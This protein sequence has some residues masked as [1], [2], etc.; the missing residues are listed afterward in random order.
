MGIEYRIVWKR[1]GCRQKAKRFVSL[2]AAQRKM[3]VLGPEPWTAFDKFSGRDEP[4]NYSC[5]D[6]HECG[7]GGLTV[8]QWWKQLGL[9]K[10]EYIHIE[11]REVGKWTLPGDTGTSVTTK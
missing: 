4:D 2:K 5:C 6:G 11:K 8:R 7:C 1:E 3:R 10:M 9:P